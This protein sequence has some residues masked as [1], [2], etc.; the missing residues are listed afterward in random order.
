MLE[1][2]TSPISGGEF[3]RGVFATQ[4]IKKGELIHVAPVI[5]Y[6]N[7]D[8]EHIEKTILDDYVYNYGANHTAI[9]LGFGSLFNHSYTPNA[10]YD[11]NFD[12]HSFDFF[13]Y[14]DIKAGDEVFINYNGEEDNMDPLWFMEEDDEGEADEDSEADG[15]EAE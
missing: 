12:T 8:H 6:P 7:E 11:I 2:K 1:V 3:R 15:K 9:L 13:A 4:D 10:T 14:T 5:P